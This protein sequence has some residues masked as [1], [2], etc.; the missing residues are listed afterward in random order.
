M[1]DKNYDFKTITK[2]IELSSSLVSILIKIQ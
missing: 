2:G 1:D